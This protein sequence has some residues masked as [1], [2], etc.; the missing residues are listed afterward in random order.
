MVSRRPPLLEI[1]QQGGGVLEGLVLLGLGLLPTADTRH[2]L[3]K[4]VRQVRLVGL[5][6]DLVLAEE[7]LG[8][9]DP[10]AGPAALGLRVLGQ[11]A[12]EPGDET[13]HAGRRPR[14]TPGAEDGAAKDC[15]A[16]L[17]VGVLHVEVGDPTLAKDLGLTLQFR[18]VVR[19]ADAHD[20]P[21]HEF[22]HLLLD[23]LPRGA[24]FRGGRRGVGS[25]RGLAGLAGAGHVV[26]GDEVGA[27][28]RTRA[29]PEAGRAEAE[30]HTP[31]GRHGQGGHAAG[32]TDSAGTS[33]GAVT[34]H[35]PRDPRDP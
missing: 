16:V 6:L 13:F 20:G 14:V 22:A 3:L 1:E 17:D 2:G 18:R 33:G 26:G 29:D 10:V 30:S 27:E 5:D 19:P 15:H 32:R 25:I 34:E 35:P 9:F 31:E 24:E 11:P 23:D 8:L 28:R 7:A 12:Y 4:H 21:R